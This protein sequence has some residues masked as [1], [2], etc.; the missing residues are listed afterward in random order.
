MGN[1]RFKNEVFSA[2][3]SKKPSKYLGGLS[4]QGLH[5]FLK[6]QTKLKFEIQESEQ[7][8]VD[9]L[10]TVVCQPLTKN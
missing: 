8:T 1:T 7:S 10:Q 2:L 3:P 9:R 5:V 6:K 4:L